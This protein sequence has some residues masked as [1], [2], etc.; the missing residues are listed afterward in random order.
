MPPKHHGALV[1]FGS[2]PGIGMHVASRFARGGFEKVVLVSRDAARLRNDAFIVY[3]TAPRVQVSTV[4]ADLA[5]PE[6]LERALRKISHVLGDTP[7]EC[8]H[9]N[10]AKAARTTMLEESEPDLRAN[11][12]VGFLGVFSSSGGS[13][14]LD[15]CDD[16]E[17]RTLTHF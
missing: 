17:S 7:V 14:W 11:I 6:D 9:N 16:A 2:G 10:A 13:C 3:S 1:I 12:E 5:S 4:A 8:V 15:K